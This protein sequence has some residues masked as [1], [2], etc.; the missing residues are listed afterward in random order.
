MMHELKN[1]VKK[2]FTENR[3]AIIASALIFFASLILGYAFQPYLYAYF[4]PLVEDLTHK[5]QTGV[6]KLTFADIF[7]NNIIIVLEMFIYGLFFC[8]SALVLAFNGFFVG[9]YAANSSNLSTVLVFTVPHGIFEFSS[10]ILACASGFVLFSF[11]CR[12][13]KTFLKQKQMKSF[14]RFL[15][16]YDENFNK[17]LQAFILL[18]IAS[19][20]MVIAGIFE[21]YITLPLGR[22]LLS[23]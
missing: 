5:V 11:A 9:Y 19:V 2:A 12:V 14:K 4:N 23:L 1:E 18:A 21:V 22:F 7:I 13:V 8:I 6:I 10:C 3:N 17:L 16:A 15:Y 20:L